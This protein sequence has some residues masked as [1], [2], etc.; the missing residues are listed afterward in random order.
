MTVDLPAGFIYRPD[1]VSEAEEKEL[2]KHV[3]NVQFSELPMR[4][5][6]ARRRVAH[7]GWLYG[8]DSWQ[9]EPGPPIPGSS[10]V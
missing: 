5:V 10:A 3:K 4:D 6:I 1:F 8:Y 2:L 9:V 7:F